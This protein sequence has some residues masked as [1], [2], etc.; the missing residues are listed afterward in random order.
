MIADACLIETF[1]FFSLDTCTCILEYSYSKTCVK[2]PL[3][4]RQNKDLY[5]NGC[6]MKVESIAELC[7]NFDLH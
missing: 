3:K 4:N 1:S 2:W 5:A 7:N 6:L